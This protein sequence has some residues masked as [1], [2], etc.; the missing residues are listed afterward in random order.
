MP[1]RLRDALGAGGLGASELDG[2]LLAL[3]AD[4][5]ALRLVDPDAPQ[6]YR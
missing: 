2:Q 3:L 5:K 1:A 4:L 6:S